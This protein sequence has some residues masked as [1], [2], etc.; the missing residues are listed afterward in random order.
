MPHQVVITNDELKKNNKRP[1]APGGLYII[2]L[3]LLVAVRTSAACTSY[4]RRLTMA[5]LPH[6]IKSAAT[7]YRHSI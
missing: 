7:H 4:V 3:L 5:Y 1:T 6:P 2:A